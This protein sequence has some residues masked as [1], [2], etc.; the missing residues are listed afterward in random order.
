MADLGT[1]FDCGE[2]LSPTLGLVSGRKA[3]AQ[4]ILRRLSTR[5]GELE[6]HPT[7]GVDVASCL[8]DD[9][10]TQELLALQQAIRAQCLED[11]RVR[12]VDVEV[13]TPTQRSLRIALRL[14]DAD[15]PFRLV[16]AASQL[17][18]AILEEAA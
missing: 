14:T 11:E 15:G 18:V 8:N 2:D 13:S 12:R 16:F 4:A 7:Y 17:T 5:R 1:D 3:L 10:G 6:R 9:L